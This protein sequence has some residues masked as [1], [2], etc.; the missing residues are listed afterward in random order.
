MAA[1]GKMCGNFPQQVKLMKCPEVQAALGSLPN[2]IFPSR[3][4]TSTLSSFS[5]HP[6][7]AFYGGHP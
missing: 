2:P 3:F 6:Q 1:T 4:P 7:H 5:L